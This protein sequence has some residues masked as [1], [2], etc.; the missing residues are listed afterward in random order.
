MMTEQRRWTS[1]LKT[2]QGSISVEWTPHGLAAIHL[3]EAG[4][5]STDRPAEFDRCLAQ[6]T[7]YFQG[8]L[9]RF[10]IPLN[11]EGLP[12]FTLRILK[13][14]A[15]IPYGKTWGYKDLAEKAEKPLASRAVG[16][17]MARNPIPIVIPCH[18]V[19]QTGGGLGGYGGGLD[20]KRFLLRLEG[21]E[22]PG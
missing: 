18:R 8:R 17:V 5:P 3:N 13:E 12:P 6:L 2:A 19:L 20:W 22:V 14:C 21:V 15:R 10:D 1:T 9:R 16:Q 4:K 7:D 11:L